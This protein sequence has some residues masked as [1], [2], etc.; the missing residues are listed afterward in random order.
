M[1]GKER[2]W[3]LLEKAGI[4]IDGNNPYDIRVFND[5]LYD[6]VFSGGPLAVGES[7]VDGW[8]DADN[9]SEF[10]T[11]ALSARLEDEIANFGLHIHILKAKLTNLQGVRR[12]FEVGERHYDAGNDLYK[13]ML[14]KRMVYTC[15]YWKDANNLGEAQE[16]KLDLV[17]KKI[18][19]KKGD[20]ILDIGCGWG[21]FA[22]VAAEH[23]GAEVVGITISKEQKALADELVEGLP[24]EI[25]I[26]DYRALNEKF[27]H[28]VS[29]GM[30]EHVGYKNY[31]E[32]MKVAH[33][34]LKD[35]GLFLL[36]TIGGNKSV[37]TTDPW[38]EKYIFPNG[39]LPSIKQIGDS[40][41]GLFVMEDWHNFGTDYDKT[42]MSW[43]ENFDKGW[44]SIKEN[45]DGRFYRMWKYYLLLSAGSFRAR[46]NQLWQIVL[47]KN[48]VSGGYTSVR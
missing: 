43:F 25:R 33:R 23:Y 34:S 17:C 12:A 32:F 24:V 1:T 5:K 47:S 38:V 42:L 22:K 20:R 29:L 9:L 10:F 44:E 36:H 16:H 21:S 13:K 31:R 35:D 45:Y 27:D 39:M 28:I 3:G 48:G 11:K 18:G 19:L 6:R 4:T 37:F 40:I 26:Q 41:D 14:D 8:W 15:G 7:Y 2:V 46:K 30:F